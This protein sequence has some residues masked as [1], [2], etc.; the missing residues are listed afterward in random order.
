[1]G[2]LY[3]ARRVYCVPDDIPASV[4]LTEQLL[5]RF[6]VQAAAEETE[7][8][9][10]CAVRWHGG[11]QWHCPG[12]GVRLQEGL[13]CGHCGERLQDL[14]WTLMELHPHRGSWPPSGS[15]RAGIQMTARSISLRM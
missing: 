13:H 4:E 15:G 3:E 1:M 9:P 11:L 5:E 8:V 6:G 10:P 7:A 2:F 14:Q 12:C